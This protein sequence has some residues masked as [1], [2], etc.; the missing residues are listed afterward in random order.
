MVIGESPLINDKTRSRT[1]LYKL[2]FLF[3]AGIYY[4]KYAK[5]IVKML[6]KFKEKQ[7]MAD[8]YIRKR[9]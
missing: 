8:I 3:E 4:L 5:I 7:N 9:E 1:K 6:A 2:R